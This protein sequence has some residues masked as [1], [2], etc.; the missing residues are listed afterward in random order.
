MTWHS[1][2]TIFLSR[3]AECWRM[4]SGN[5]VFLA[6]L[7]IVFK[8]WHTFNPSESRS[9]PRINT[10]NPHVDQ[11]KYACSLTRCTEESMDPETA[12]ATWSHSSLHAKLG[13]AQQ[14]LNWGNLGHSLRRIQ[15][16]AQVLHSQTEVL[17]GLV[18]WAVLVLCDCSHQLVEMILPRGGQMLPADNAS[19]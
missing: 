11:R 5:T 12:F 14:I 16:G 15:W 1:G 18:I 17:P 2:Q 7:D 10:L 8:L 13:H 4:E 3:W 9:F 19:R 6:T